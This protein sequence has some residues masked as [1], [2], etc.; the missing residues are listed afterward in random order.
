MK[1]DIWADIYEAYLKEIEYSNQHFCQ[2][3]SD[4][5]STENSK[6]FLYLLEQRII[7]IQKAIEK[8]D[9]AMKMALG[10]EEGEK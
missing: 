3:S 9:L 1:V 7:D 10:I 2:Q 4:T 5:R 8:K 6:A